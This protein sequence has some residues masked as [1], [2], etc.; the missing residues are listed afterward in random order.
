M[1]EWEKDGKAFISIMGGKKAS[2]KYQ[3]KLEFVAAPN[4]GYRVKEW[5]Y[6]GDVLKDNKSNFFTAII[7]MHSQDVFTVTV[8]FEIIPSNESK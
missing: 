5:R 1:P 3:Y 4:D 6:N 2:E 8:E 7:S